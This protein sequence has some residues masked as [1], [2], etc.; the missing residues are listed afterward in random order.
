M[1]L[2]LAEDEKALNTALTEILKRSG[3]N[4]TSVFN[5]EDALLYLKEYTFDAVILD[6][7]MPKIDGLTTLKTLRADKNSVPV[8][9]LT[10]KSEVEDKIIGLDSGADDYLAKP[11]E[12]K[13][14]LARIRAI[15]RRKGTTDENLAGFS[16]I[17]LNKDDCGMSSAGGE[18]TLTLKGGRSK[19]LIIE[20]TVESVKK[21]DL[22][23]FFERFYRADESRNSE[24][25]GHGIGLSIAKEIADK[26]GLKI[27]ANSPDGKSVVFTVNF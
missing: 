3:Y 23:E 14:L 7:M 20:N 12:V 5:G 6:I 24:T 25:G 9:L 22:S 19:K 27:T 10:A 11:F 1:N 13:E 8:I 16:D 21:G 26:S 18:A 15:T 17:K 2:L 4:V